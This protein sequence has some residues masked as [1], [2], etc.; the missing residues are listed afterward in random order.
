MNVAVRCLLLGALAWLPC[1]GTTIERGYYAPVGSAFGRQ[2]EPWRQQLGGLE[3]EVRCQGVYRNTVDGRPTRSAHV[4]L[5]FTRTQAGEVVIPLES[6]RLDFID[7]GQKSVSLAAAE[8][9]NGRRRTIGAL[10]LNP[11]SRNSFDV[12][13][14]DGQVEAPVPQVLRLRWASSVAG[15]PPSAW[16]DCQFQRIEPDDPR[17]PRD[18]ALADAEFG[19]RNGY[20]LPGP[21]DLGAR[22]LRDSIEARPHYLFHSP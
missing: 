4:Q 1:C 19:V 9:W 12:F 10:L 2:L 14:D 20:Y 22:G 5:E 11:W 18:L 17:Y 16:G 15:G 6:L 7:A 8:V 21:G 13:F 3:V